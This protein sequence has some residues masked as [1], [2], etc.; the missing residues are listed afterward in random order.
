MNTKRN[1]FGEVTW[2]L[3]YLRMRQC[4][5]MA[6]ENGFPELWNTKL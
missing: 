5:G 2:E 3:L 1:I 6:T 4:V